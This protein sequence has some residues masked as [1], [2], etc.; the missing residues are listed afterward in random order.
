MIIKR[1]PRREDGIRN[2]EAIEQRPCPPA[3]VL[4]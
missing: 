3:M 4:A 2:M 1:G